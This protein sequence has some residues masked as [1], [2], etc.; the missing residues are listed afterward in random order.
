MYTVKQEYLLRLG[1]IDELLSFINNIEGYK[2]VSSGGP[3]SLSISIKLKSSSVLMMYNAIESTI[4]NTLKRIHEI[5]N[6][7]EINYT[8]A[9]REIR[10]LVVTY[11]HSKSLSK[12]N[13]HDASDC[14]EELSF[15]ILDKNKLNIQFEE[16]IKYYSLYSGNIDAKLV[17]EV[18]S[19]YGINIPD[20]ST[21]LKTIKDYRNHLAHGER[22]FE[23]CGREISF[24][25]LSALRNATDTF[26]NSMLD[27]V[28]TFCINKAYKEHP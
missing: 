17:R 9:T 22:T 16:M 26:I 3:V 11:Y 19:K 21:E 24:Q 13:S 12:N 6:K 10:R 25:H 4:T 20:K 1:E 2:V 8:D 18:L 28:D 14:L 23:E 15:N 5:I 7:D 27:A